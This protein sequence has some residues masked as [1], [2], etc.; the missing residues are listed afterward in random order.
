MKKYLVLIIALGLSL[1]LIITGCSAKKAASSN[2]AIELSK[3]MQTVEQKAHYLIGQA[4]AF[5]GSKD[6]KQAVDIAQYILAYVDKDST[7][8][9]SLLEK[10][11]AQLTALAQQKAAELKSKLG[12]K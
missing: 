7:D 3:T 5:Y 4:K 1:G 9:K 10:A 11:K 2:E 12:V 6:F 8:A